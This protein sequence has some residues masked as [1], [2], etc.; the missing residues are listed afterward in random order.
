MGSTL[1]RSPGRNTHGGKTRRVQCVG[2]DN[3]YVLVIIKDIRHI[4]MLVGL[5]SLGWF[6]Y[7]KYWVCVFF[8]CLVTMGRWRRE[9]VCHVGR[10]VRCGWCRLPDWCCGDGHG[11]SLGF[12]ASWIVFWIL[13]LVVGYYICPLFMMIPPLLD[14]SGR[15]TWQG[16]IWVCGEGFWQT[17]RRVCGN[18]IYDEG[19]KFGKFIA[20]FPQ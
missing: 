11:W 13:V 4:L 5:M 12:K 19:Q 8:C 16:G 6:V 18:Q 7:C 15:D 20:R 9:L 14:W 10:I 3:R 2:P 17:D 1:S